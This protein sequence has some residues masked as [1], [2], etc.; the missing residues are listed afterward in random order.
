MTD[1]QKVKKA[2]ELLEGVMLDGEQPNEVDKEI[3]D[4]ITSLEIA[5]DIME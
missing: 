4:A 5:L 3:Y 2:L 1:R